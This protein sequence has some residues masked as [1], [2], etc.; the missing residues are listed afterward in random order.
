MPSIDSGNGATGDKV[1]FL[2]SSGAYPRVPR[3][4]AIETHFAWVFLAGDAAYK[5]KKPVHQGSMDYSTL[6]RRRRACLAELTL[7]RRL[8]PSVYL[9]VIPLCVRRD[10][11]MALEA[12]GRVIEWMLKMRRLPSRRMLDRA[13]AAHAVS[14]SD[15]EV[16]ARLLCR[17]FS[18]ARRV[19]LT[20]TAYLQRLGAQAAH[21]LRE[22]SMSDL[23]LDRDLV[24][25]VTDAQLMF[26]SRERA[27]LARRAVLLRDGHGDLRPEHIFLGSRA[28]PACV[29]DCL[30]FDPGLRRLDPLEEMAFLLLECE[31]LGAMAVGA[32]LLRYYQEMLPDGAPTMLVDF[33][34]SRRATVR[35]LI[36]A[37]HVR[38]RR[39]AREHRRF[40]AI[41]HGYLHDALRFARRAVAASSRRRE[42]QLRNRRRAS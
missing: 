35:A 20:R 40:R 10:G 13:L 37:W 33:Y 8:A 2:R 38:D 4:T 41:A 6:A 34:R 27:L 16:V 31:R 36:A 30:E 11:H 23:G 15:I 32:R 22:L 21:A 5:L 39:F 1:R 12:G 3:V 18:A 42:S 9:G 26:M 14:K 19:P 29:I 17:F 7:N 28:Q 24:R 25:Q